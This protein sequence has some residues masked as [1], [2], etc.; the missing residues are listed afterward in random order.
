[1]P[2]K[3]RYKVRVKLGFLSEQ[4]DE[5]WVEKTLPQSDSYRPDSYREQ[6]WPNRIDEHSHRVFGPKIA[7]W[8][9]NR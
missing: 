9:S 1:M 4:F 2:L 8:Y 6:L 7:P 3:L 5:Q